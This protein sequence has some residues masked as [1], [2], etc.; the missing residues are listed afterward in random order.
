MRINKERIAMK[1]NVEIRKVLMIALSCLFALCMGLTVAFSGVLSLKVRALTNP[2]EAQL[3]MIDG[4]EVY[5]DGYA[6]KFTTEIEESYYNALKSQYDSVQ[7]C[8]EIAPQ[9]MEQVVDVYNQALEFV[10]GKAQFYGV[11][12]YSSVDAAS[13]KGIAAIEMTAKAFVLADGQK[14]YAHRNDT[15]RSMRALANLALVRGDF[16]D[17]P[18]V[19]AH[20][21][22]YLG[23]ITRQSQIQELNAQQ[24]VVNFDQPVTGRL[25]VNA[26]RI[27]KFLVDET[28]IDIK[29]YIGAGESNGEITVS[30]MGD[31]QYDV[32][33]LQAVYT[34]GLPLIYQDEN[35]S[36]TTDYKIV[37]QDGN[38]S[39]AE[40]GRN[41]AYM[42]NEMTGIVIESTWQASDYGY[43]IGVNNYYSSERPLNN[44][45]KQYSST[46]KYISIGYTEVLNQAGITYDKD[47]LK[48]AGGFMIVV[49]DNS[50]FLFGG[51][52]TASDYRKNSPCYA[53][54]DLLQMVFG[55]EVYGTLPKSVQ[56]SR[57][58]SSNATKL[59]PYQKYVYGY[60]YQAG[61]EVYVSD[62]LNYKSLPNIENRQIQYDSISGDTQGYGIYRPTYSYDHG[63]SIYAVTYDDYLTR[64]D[65][66]GEGVKVWKCSCGSVQISTTQP[67]CTKCNVLCA[68]ITTTIEG[69]KKHT[70][71]TCNS[72]YHIRVGFTAPTECLNPSC[73]STSYG[74]VS[75]T[76]SGFWHTNFFWLPIGENYSEHPLWYGEDGDGNKTLSNGKFTRQLCFTAH[77][78]STELEAMVNACVVKVQNTLKVYKGQLLENQ[79]YAITLSDHDATRHCEC[80]TCKASYAKYGSMSGVQIEF[81]NKVAEKVQTWMNANADYKVNLMIMPFAYHNTER[82]S[83]STNRDINAPVEW[84][85]ATNK[86][87]GID[88]LTAYKGE[89]VSTSV[90]LVTWYD[91]V[92]TMPE[93]E[94]DGT[95]YLYSQVKNP[96]GDVK[97]D[98]N[99]QRRLIQQWKDFVGDTQIYLWYNAQEYNYSTFPNYS[100]ELF[101]EDFYQ[102]LV[103]EDGDDIKWIYNYATES[104]NAGSGY[105]NLRMYVTTKLNWDASLSPAELRDAWFKGIFKNDAVREKMLSAFY[106]E[107]NMAIYAKYKYTNATVP[108]DASSSNPSEQQ[109]FTLA[110]NFGEYWPKDKLI[111][112]YNMYQDVYDEIQNESDAR[113]KEE[114]LA[115]LY[116]EWYFPTAML[117]RYYL[118]DKAILSMQD[119]LI[120]T[121]RT[122]IDYTGIDWDVMNPELV[123]L[124]A[125]VELVAQKRNYNGTAIDST[126]KP[127]AEYGIYDAT[128]GTITLDS[129][130]NDY[131][132][133]L[134]LR[135]TK[136]VTY[137]GITYEKGTIVAKIHGWDV[138]YQQESYDDVWG[139]NFSSGK[140]YYRNSTKGSYTIHCTFGINYGANWLYGAS[141]FN[142]NV[143]IK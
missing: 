110:G 27:D 95:D 100:E 78:N 64:I 47:E 81:I 140:L 30:V 39:A 131:R 130:Q 101:S 108:S 42:V 80:Q 106:Y 135:L 113:L 57:L 26:K 36:L 114:M 102:F 70:A 118:N 69:Y 44:A 122:I 67:T 4:A 9:G 21:A 24:T 142:V 68:D 96:D 136:D 51:D 92:Q 58:E 18:E 59:P 119:E 79:T 143:E 75:N 86:W 116:N 5:L 10:D 61:N 46:D 12:D 94:F 22:S 83:E 43:N 112:L 34:A 105:H 93:N 66:E 23:K 103:G 141:I 7:L 49:K 33:S 77:G 120:S 88:G 40:A 1:R 139:L 3:K 73:T 31:N 2:D 124:N 32:T 134:A 84:D 133:D 52:D 54:D 129:S 37:T 107:M 16:K 72:C 63:L 82:D 25:Y 11:L 71:Y 62:T 6:I 41:F 111:T 60:S 65:T 20:L 137:G 91:L 99:E 50:I 89:N 35:G 138:K 45:N 76:T 13:V 126:Y 87:V 38:Y 28:S 115:Y 128:T 74:Y 55:F 121:L 127:I 132:Y 123:Y 14:I 19:E 90:F 48:K 29:N 97:Y 125:S 53:V 98:Y 8:T 109:F 85:D 104:S 56:D 17:A 15:I 117:L